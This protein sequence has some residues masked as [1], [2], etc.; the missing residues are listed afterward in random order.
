MYTIKK[1]IDKGINMLYEHRYAL[2]TALVTFMF[3]SCAGFLFFWGVYMDKMIYDS[4]ANGKFTDDVSFENIIE[5]YGFDK[6]FCLL[7][8]DAIENIEV[9]FRT[10][11]ANVI[12][13]AEKYKYPPVWIEI[14]TWTM[15]NIRQLSTAVNRGILFKVV[16]ACGAKTDGIFNGWIKNLTSLRNVCA[17]HSRLWNKQLNNI[18]ASNRELGDLHKIFKTTHNQQRNKNNKNPNNRVYYYCLVIWHLLQHINP[19]SKWNKR[20]SDLMDTLPTHI[21]HVGLIHMGFTNNWQ[22]HSFWGLK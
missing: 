10:K 17:H 13:G 3:L 22:E 14:E 4:D 8:L 15:G 12:S 5:L 16:T 11:V 6:K 21:P 7:I 1:Y 2:A 19:Q 20:V 18:D 9:Y